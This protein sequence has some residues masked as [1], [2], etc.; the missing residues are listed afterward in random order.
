M[1][2][3]SACS[4]KSTSEDAAP[5]DASAAAQ[6]P[7]FPTAS[8]IDPNTATEEELTEVPGLNAAAVQAIVAA[9]PIATPSQLDAAI[10]DSLDADARKAVYALVFVKVGLNSGAEKDY[11]LIPSTMS[12]GKLA[13]E[14][15]E[16]RPYDSME[17]F[18]REMSKYVSDAEV[19]YLKRFVTLD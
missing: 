7:A 14:F 13:H 1:T 18:S 17:E 16:Y 9:R 4:N 8:L 15:E 11:Q 10:G 3:L 2:F 19:T 6:A 5:N 12:P